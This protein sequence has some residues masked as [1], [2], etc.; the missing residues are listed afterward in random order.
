MTVIDHRKLRLPRTAR[1]PEDIVF[2]ARLTFLIALLIATGAPR[3]DVELHYELLEQ[4]AVQ[5]ARQ[6]ES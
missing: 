2:D 3:G 5:G 6:G 4:R 1:T